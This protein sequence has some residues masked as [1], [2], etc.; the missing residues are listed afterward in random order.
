ERRFVRRRGKRQPA[1]SLQVKI[2]GAG[3]CWRPLGGVVPAVAASLEH[4]CA[5][6]I[7]APVGTYVASGFSRTRTLTLTLTGTFVLQIE[8]EE[9]QF[10]LAAVVPR[11]FRVEEDVPERIAVAARP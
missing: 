11:R 6:Q 3:G 10:D 2:A 7:Q 4:D 9:R 8:I 5:R 1:V